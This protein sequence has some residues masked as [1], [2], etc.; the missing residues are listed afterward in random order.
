MHVGLMVGTIRR[1]TLG[2]T[3]DAIVE[4]NVHHLQYHVPAGTVACRGSQG[5]R[6]STDYNLG[7][8]R[9]L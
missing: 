7:T 6:R 4:H 2:A 5:D 3:L 1:K 8:W 9:H